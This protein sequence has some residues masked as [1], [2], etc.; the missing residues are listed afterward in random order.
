MSGPSN[1]IMPESSDAAVIAAPGVSSL[2]ASSESKKASATPF[3]TYTRRF[4]IVYGA[5]GVILAGALAVAVTVYLQSGP[6]AS[7]SWSSWKPVAGSTA[8]VT[9]SIAT[10]V[11]QEYRLNT[12]GAELIGVEPEALTYT[13]GTRKLAISAVAV[14][15]KA[16]SNTGIVF[17]PTT[18]TWADLLCGLGTS[19]SIASGTATNTRGRLVRREALELALYTFKF[20]PAVD[21][22]VTYMPPPPG[23]TSS[24][25]LYFQKANLTQQLSQPLDKTLPLAT[26]PLPSSPDLT[27]APTI[28]KLTL[29][30]LY[31][32][33]LAALQ[34][35]S[36]AIV[37]VPV[38]S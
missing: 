32:Y 23:S 36:L 28:D 7:P 6:L 37:L 2:S 3:V 33:S 38:A 20:A 29:P 24:T 17:F 30:A 15:K 25:L 18:T 4:N 11:A 19:C 12:A 26:P 10:H 9:S 34:D 27:E 31:S 14:R 5:L 13:S 8:Q 16:N 22:L 1:D 21:S 35:G